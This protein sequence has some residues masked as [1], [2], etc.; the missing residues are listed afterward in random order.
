MLHAVGQGRVVLEASVEVVQEFAHVLLRRGADRSVTLEEV[1]ELRGVCHLYAFDED[2]LGEAT[3]LLSRYRQ[4]GV[5]D[6][7]HAA[8]ALHAGV[9]QILSTDR[10][11]DEVAEVARVD[12]SDPSAPWAS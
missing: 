7:V 11:F 3:R 2:V 8:T 4:L 1:D 9:D 12:P 6:A 10:A 5:R